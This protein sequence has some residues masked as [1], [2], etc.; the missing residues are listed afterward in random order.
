VRS[1][2]FAADAVQY[3]G[4]MASLGVSSIAKL[5]RGGSKPGV[6]N[7]KSFYDTGTALVAAKPLG[8]LKVQ[9]PAQGASACWGS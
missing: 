7:G 6:T 2:E 5:A 1:G 8:G 4:K 3:P 9:S